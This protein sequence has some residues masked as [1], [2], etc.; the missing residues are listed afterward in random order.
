MN[1][2]RTIIPVILFCFIEILLL[3]MNKIFW[4]M[5]FFWEYAG[6]L[7]V[8]L[9]FLVYPFF[10]RHIFS[11]KIYWF[12]FIY[13]VISLFVYFISCIFLLWRL[14]EIKSVFFPICFVWLFFAFVVLDILIRKIFHY[15]IIGKS[16][17][18]W[19]PAN[20]PLILFWTIVI[21]LTIISW[22]IFYYI[23]N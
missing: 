7:F 17:F 2:Q 1:V 9:P 18:T 19:N 16:K 14:Q 22:W 12:S 21:V 20:I 13:S 4:D 5:N 3:I 8:F 15:K 23:E 11:T 6:E 10:S